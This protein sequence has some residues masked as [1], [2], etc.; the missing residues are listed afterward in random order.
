MSEIV[1][2]AFERRKKLRRMSDEEEDYKYSS[3]EEYS[4]EDEEEML[5]VSCFSFT[6]FALRRCAE[7]KLLLFFHKF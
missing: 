2:K 6:Y 7:S 4:E 1:Q 3:G 5:E